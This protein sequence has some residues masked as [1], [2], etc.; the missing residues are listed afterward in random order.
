MRGPFQ[1]E[2]YGSVNNQPWASRE[3]AVLGA[4]LLRLML[5]DLWGC[6]VQL[7]L[8]WA[9]QIQMLDVVGSEEE[10]AHIEFS[11]T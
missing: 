5:D 6:R 7:I 10:K 4:M 9:P 11:R 3:E 8:N 2:L 1:K